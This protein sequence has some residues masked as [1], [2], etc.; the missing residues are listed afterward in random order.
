MVLS[1]TINIIKI[2]ED[3]QLEFFLKEKVSRIEGFKT[4]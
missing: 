2:K 3:R 4:H 1:D